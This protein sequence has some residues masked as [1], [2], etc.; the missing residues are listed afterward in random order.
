MEGK[1]KS[2]AQQVEDAQIEMATWSPEMRAS[3]HL[4]GGDKRQ[5]RVED[6]FALA[7]SYGR[8]EKV[9]FRVPGTSR[10]HKVDCVVMDPAE[11]G[12]FVS[13]V[14]AR[15]LENQ[16]PPEGALLDRFAECRRSAQQNGPDMPWQKFLQSYPWV[17]P[18]WN[19]AYTLGQKPNPTR[20]QPK[21]APVIPPWISSADDELTRLCSGLA[22]CQSL[23]EDFGEH[24]RLMARF[25]N[26]KIEAALN[27]PGVSLS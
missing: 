4:Q 17:L 27:T 16:A 19:D 26:S 7:A 22:F 11:I 1:S 23:G 25:I 6:D 3:V 8:K 9:S 13:V 2:L 18:M 12:K 15:A 21:P 14:T 20:G 24:K 10:S 5:P